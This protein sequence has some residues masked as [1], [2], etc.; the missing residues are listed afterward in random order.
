MATITVTSTADS[1]AGSLRQALADAVSGDKIVFDATAFPEETETTIYLSSQLTLP[2]IDLEIDG[3]ATWTVPYVWR[4][5]DGTMTQVYIDEEHPA[6]TGETILQRLKTRVVLDRQELGRVVYGNNSGVITLKGLTF[7]NGKGLNSSGIGSGIYLNGTSENALDSCVFEDCSGYGNGAGVYAD[8]TSNVDINN[9]FFENCVSR[10]AAVGGAVSLFGTNEAA[11]EYCVFNSCR[12]AGYGG[13]IHVAGS[14]T[15]GVAHCDFNYCS[16]SGGGGAAHVFTN[17]AFSDCVFNG[18]SSTA[19]AGSQGGA[20]RIDGGS[21]SFTSCVFNQCEAPYG[22]ALYG[23]SGATAVFNRCLFAGMRGTV[24][25]VRR[26]FICDA[27]ATPKLTLTMTN[28]V[29]YG[30]GA[31]SSYASVVNLFAS[32]STAVVKYCTFG[33]NLTGVGE[34]RS[35]DSSKITLFDSLIGSS[36]NFAS[37][38][39]VD[40]QNNDFRLG[41]G[42]TYC[43]GATGYQSG[44]VDYLGRPRKANGAVG[45]YEGSWFVVAANGTATISANVSADYADIGNGATITF[46]GV[47]RTLTATNGATIGAAT[48]SAPICAFVVVPA[49]ALAPTATFSNVDLVQYSAGATSFVATRTGAKWTASDLSVPVVVQKNVEDVWSTIA[50]ASGGSTSFTPSLPEG[51]PLRLFD[52]INFFT[53]TAVASVEF[54]PWLDYDKTITVAAT[55]TAAR[56]ST[57]AF[58]DHRYITTEAFILMSSYFNSGESPVLF[59]RIS[60]SETGTII[61]PEDVESISYSCY[62]KTSS[63]ASETKTVVTGHSNATVPSSAIKSELVTDDARWTLDQT[64]YNFIFEPNSRINPIFPTP[65]NYE[66]D[67]VVN[68]VDANPAPIKFEI[69]VN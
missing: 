18:C 42:S 46:S 66:I 16:S 38:G 59:A 37:V 40:N 21:G 53:A 34:F 32:T 14:S 27:S 10:G 63:W 39:F 52:G 23:I 22:D 15:C 41:Y 11:L 1:G 62:K 13:A 2:D 60:D 55:E 48:F 61:D 17:A 4:D 67:V 33:N 29:A 54:H 69:Q 35:G 28:C 50:N 36:V 65:G 30:N 20:V 24:G 58:L 56:Y 45:A 12:A 49:G 64:G 47:D 6:Q 68:F 57:T 51:T 3:G 44:D 19:N 43:S 25:G 7:R 31:G 9:C 8:D 26:G 5:V